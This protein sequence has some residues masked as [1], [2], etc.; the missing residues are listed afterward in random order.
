MLTQVMS[1]QHFP[2]YRAGFFSKLARLPVRIAVA[3]VQLVG[4]DSIASAFFSAI[5]AAIHLLPVPTAA[6]LW[7][8]SSSLH[9][10]YNFC[11]ASL[12][13]EEQSNSTTLIV[14]RPPVVPAAR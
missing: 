13:L 10:F 6:T 4:M 3:M 14:H 9:K 11:I 8:R 2:T 5:K 7:G 12:H 1:I